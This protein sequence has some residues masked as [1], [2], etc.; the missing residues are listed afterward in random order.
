MLF[1][2]QIKNFKINAAGCVTKYAASIVANTD[3]LIEHIDLATKTINVGAV[4]WN[5]FSVAENDHNR[6]RH[7]RL[8][9]GDTFDN[10]VS[11]VGPNVGFPTKN[12]EIEAVV[13]T[14]GVPSSTGGLSNISTHISNSSNTGHKGPGP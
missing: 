12:V 6:I 1:R 4:V 11:V 9:V 7:M 14:S 8:R 13:I 2:S 10:A 5:N 3:C